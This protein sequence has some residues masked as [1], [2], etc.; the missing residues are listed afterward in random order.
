MFLDNNFETS[1]VA[2]PIAVEAIGRQKWYVRQR[3]QFHSLIHD[4][5]ILQSHDGRH[6]YKLAVMRFALDR[7][8][9]LKYHSRDDGFFHK[10]NLFPGL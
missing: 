1:P 3:F 6:S 4:D 9:D 2:I 5:P 8:L 7:A 10:L